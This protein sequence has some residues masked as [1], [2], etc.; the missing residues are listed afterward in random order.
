VSC[1]TRTKKKSRPRSKAEALANLGPQAPQLV[2]AEPALV[3]EAMP[4]Y[5]LCVEI[6]QGYPS[7]GPLAG[8][9]PARSRALPYHVDRD[10]R[11]RGG[12]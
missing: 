4:L 1:F 8:H 10:Q 3:K 5:K 6:E 11:A 7:G 2:A 12:I 9:A